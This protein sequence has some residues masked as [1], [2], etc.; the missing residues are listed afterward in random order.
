MA[1]LIV[2]M[3]NDADAQVVKLA[4]NHLGGECDIFYSNDFAGGAEWSFDPDSNILHTGFRGREEKW[5]F[6]KYS[7]VWMRRP[8]AIVPREHLE[9]LR[10]RVAAERECTA[11]FNSILRII[12]QGK[13]VASPIGATRVG[14]EKCYQ[15]SVAR[16]VGLRMPA[17]M[18][19]NSAKQILDFYRACNGEMIY[20]TLAPM[21]WNLNSPAYSQVRTTMITD[22][23]LLLSCD[24]L[25]AP[26]IY[27]EKIEKQAEIRVTILG[28][29][30]LAVQKSFPHRS[31]TGI[32]VDWRGMHNG[33]VYQRHELPDDIVKKC[34]LL[35]RKMNLVMG[36]FDIALDYSG[37]YYFLEVNP[38]G[39]FIWSD[40]LCQD[41]NHL[42]A[43]AEFLMSGDP[44]FKYKNTNKV[45]YTQFIDRSIYQKLNALE[46]RDH[47]GDLYSFNYGVASVRLVEPTPLTEE[48]ILSK[49]GE[50]YGV[51][52]NVQ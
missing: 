47:F 43:M 22:E 24:L 50:Q 25:S 18:I 35:L 11:F 23:N 37:N 1:V 32:D 38:Q 9:D 13:F 3:P 36:S 17:T 21:V 48:Q 52:E 26:G 49:M 14:Y 12:E 44:A 33:A 30:V 19:S 2:T 39:Q 42:E 31:A 29:T 40:Q 46:Q 51:A 34:L 16:Q 27:Q 15:F 6:E 8:G 41:V 4:I 28:N 7:S 20:K 10:E 45:H 5:S